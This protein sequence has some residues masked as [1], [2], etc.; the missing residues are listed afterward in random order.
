MKDFSY[1]SKEYY[2]DKAEKAELTLKLLKKAV[3]VEMSN[4]VNEAVEAANNG[5]YS[6]EEIFDKINSYQA[7]LENAESSLKYAQDEVAKAEG[8]KDE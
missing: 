1:G 4:I 8:K 7:I 3:A 2:Q 6:T 5:E